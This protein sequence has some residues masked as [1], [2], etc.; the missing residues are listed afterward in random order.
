MVET[1]PMYIV[2]M[3]RKKTS[4]LIALTLNYVDAQLPEVCAAE[5]SLKEDG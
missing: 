3:L 5:S 4:I 1:I 2:V